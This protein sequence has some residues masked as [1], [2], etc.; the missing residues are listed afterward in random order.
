MAD[1]TFNPIPQMPAA[2][3]APVAAPDVA[4]EVVQLQYVPAIQGVSLYYA[5][6]QSGSHPQLYSFDVNLK[7]WRVAQS[8]EVERVMLS[9]GIPSNVITAM[10][11]FRF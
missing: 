9:L 4:P 3:P 5:L 7:Q 10:K 2:V 1:V 11:A 8:N 6:G